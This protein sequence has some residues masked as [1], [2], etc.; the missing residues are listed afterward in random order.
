MADGPTGSTVPRRQLGRRL[1]ELR[2]RSRLTVRMAASALEWSETKLWRIETGQTSLRSL[3]VE[4]MCRMYG[5]PQGTTEALMALS[6]ETKA[7][8]WWHAYSDVI[9]DSLDLHLGL[10]EAASELCWFTSELVPGLLQTRE[11]ARTILRAHYSE[12]SEEEIERL[13][14][15]RLKRQSLLTRPT[16]AP[17]AKLVFNEAVLR[18]AVGGEEIMAAQLEHLLVMTNRPNLSLRVLPFEVGFHQG[19][20]SRSFGLF[21]FPVG[22]D[23]RDM[24]PPTVHLEGLTGTLYLDKPGE[25][26]R[27]EGAFTAIWSAAL[28]EARSRSFFHEAAR[29]FRHE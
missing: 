4:A 14:D 22:R 11:Y 25:I 16:E 24:E 26:E 28:D 18:R 2:M 13:V 6:K 21:R 27:Y 1:R 5:A 17:V 10:E 23:G 19:L 12:A 29:E 7:H 20:L 3:D 8:G 9:R 15:L